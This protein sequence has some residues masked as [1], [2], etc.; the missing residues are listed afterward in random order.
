MSALANMPMLIEK[1]EEG[2]AEG[3][4]EGI[5]E[6]VGGRFEGDSVGLVIGITT[7]TMIAVTRREETI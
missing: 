6:S 2:G 3:M 5:G 1:I 7:A 4:D